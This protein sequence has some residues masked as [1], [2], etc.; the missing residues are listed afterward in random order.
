MIALRHVAPSFANVAPTAFSEWR[1]WSVAVAVSL[2]LHAALLW[3]LR[4]ASPPTPPIPAAPDPGVHWLTATL[5]PAPPTQTKT[6]STAQA[7]TR[8]ITKP[9]KQAPIQPQPASPALAAAPAPAPI[10]KRE[11]T[12]QAQ[13]QVQTPPKPPPPPSPPAADA[14]TL[15]ALPK[16]L[17]ST[18]PA[19]PAAPAAAGA[20]L[21]LSRPP[22]LLPDKV[23]P[24]PR[25]PALSQRLGEQGT[26]WLRAEVGTDG[27]VQ[28]VQLLKPSPYP[29]LNRAAQDAVSQWQYHP[30]TDQGTPVAMW[31]EVPVRFELR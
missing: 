22:Q 15:P 8:P 25:Y 26:V 31:L 24:P 3:G 10:S 23:Q 30:G 18:Q 6:Q 20:Q 17:A 4:G 5:L 29:R 9:T 2:A 27:R 13:P 16:A 7:T 11:P 1:R 21:A 12:V 14:P 28:Q 19:V